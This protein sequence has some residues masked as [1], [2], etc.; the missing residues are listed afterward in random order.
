MSYPRRSRPLV[1][2]VILLS[3]ALASLAWP[4]QPA[5]NEP[6]LP[7]RVYVPYEKLKNVL[8]TEG[9]GVFLPYKEFERLWLNAQ[10][11]PAAAPEAS[12]GR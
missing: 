1:S 5:T 7:A 3:L 11:R 12:S 10:G 4:Q 2:L 6:T 9:Q 8:D